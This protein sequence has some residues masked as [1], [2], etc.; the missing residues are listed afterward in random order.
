MTRF[1]FH[2]GFCT[3]HLFLM[4]KPPTKSSLLSGPL[5]L[6]LE[7]S[8]QVSLKKVLKA[9]GHFNLLA[10]MVFAF[11]STTSIIICSVTRKWQIFAKSLTEFRGKLSNDINDIKSEVL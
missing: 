7:N 9:Q 8:D 5:C 4:F 2:L 3:E 10:V 1:L 11:L 6:C